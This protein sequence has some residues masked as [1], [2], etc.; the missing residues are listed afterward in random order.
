MRLYD[1]AITKMTYPRQGNDLPVLARR[2]SERLHGDFAVDDIRPLH[3]V[4]PGKYA[5][6]GT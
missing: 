3:T 5:I 6:H 1:I 4:Q 2:A